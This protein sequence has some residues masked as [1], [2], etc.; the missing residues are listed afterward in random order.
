MRV[1]PGY[2]VPVVQLHSVV[3]R[4]LASFGTWHIGT[5][6]SLDTG[7]GCVPARRRARSCAGDRLPLTDSMRPAMP[8]TIGAEKLVPTL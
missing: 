1:I 7:N 3:C 4:S 5:A 6:G 8:D 2:H